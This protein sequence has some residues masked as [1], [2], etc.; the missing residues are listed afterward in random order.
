MSNKRGKERQEFLV[1]ILV[2]YVMGFAFLFAN[3]AVG[4]T[5]LGFAFFL[6]MLAFPPVWKAVRTTVVWLVETAQRH[7]IRNDETKEKSQ[8][9]TTTKSIEEEGEVANAKLQRVISILESCPLPPRF[10]HEPENDAETWISAQLVHDFPD[11]KRQQHYSIYH[12]RF[13]I[14]IDDIGIEVKLPK[15]ARDM[16]TL[17]G[18]IQIYLKRFSHVVA[19]IINYYGISREIIDEF[20]RDMREYGGRVTVIERRI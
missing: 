18:Q 7:A 12:S 2:L 15:G 19:F 14:E 16:A 3:I 20:K 6:T 5:L 8:E 17:R 11:H 9:L 10:R 13:D 4:I 1:F